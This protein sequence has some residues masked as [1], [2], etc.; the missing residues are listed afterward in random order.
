MPR[1]LSF[2]L[3]VVVIF[4]CTS[5]KVTTVDSAISTTT[6]Y[7]VRHAEKQKGSDPMLTEAGEERALKLLS[8]LKDQGVDAVYSTP[9]NR[10]KSTAAPTAKHF[11]FPLLNLQMR[12]LAKSGFQSWMNPIIRISLRSRLLEIRKLRSN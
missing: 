3:F 8:I 12:S 9:Y 5:T 2:L 11:G 10:T 1:I 6:I 4:G 7:L